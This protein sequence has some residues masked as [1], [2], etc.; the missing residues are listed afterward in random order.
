MVAIGLALEGIG[1]IDHGGAVK[2]LGHGEEL[3]FQAFGG[4]RQAGQLRGG[5]FQQMLVDSYRR[6]AATRGKQGQCKKAAED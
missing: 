4:L 2:G 1:A 6:F 3:H 5:V